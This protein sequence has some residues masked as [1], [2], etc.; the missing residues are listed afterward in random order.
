MQASCFSPKIRTL[1]KHCPDTTQT[2]GVA[3]GHV[4]TNQTPPKQAG[5]RPDN[6]D[7]TRTVRTVPTTTGLCGCRVASGSTGKS[8]QAGQRPPDRVA[9]ALRRPQVA[10]FTA[11]TVAAVVRLLGTCTPR[12]ATAHHC[13]SRPPAATAR[14]ATAAVIHN[15][16]ATP[17]Q[18]PCRINM[19][20][21]PRS[22]GATSSDT[23]PVNTSEYER[24]LGDAVSGIERT[25]ALGHTTLGKIRRQHETIG[26][27]ARRSDDTRR[28][29]QDAKKSLRAL[30]CRLLREKL[31]LSTTIAI[32]FTV[33]VFLFYLLLRHGGRFRSDDDS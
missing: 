12:S 18:R 27:A 3:S 15:R 29:T 9:Y 14:M 20:S 16:S 13:L 5:Q 1:S 8:K 31:C 23:R 17:P 30:Y 11:R 25:E 2:G 19:A 6:P 4:R 22:Y 7:D 26:Y 10:A 33:D 24:L 21:P 28:I 32:L